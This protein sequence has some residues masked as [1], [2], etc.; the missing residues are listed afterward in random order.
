M[1]LSHADDGLAVLAIKQPPPPP[2]SVAAL[3]LL[4]AGGAG[5][6]SPEYA[7]ARLGEAKRVISASNVP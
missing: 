2:S 6:I 4:T 3:A 7:N 1:I 5:G